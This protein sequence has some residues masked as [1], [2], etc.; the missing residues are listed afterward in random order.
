MLIHGIIV[1]MIFLLKSMIEIKRE[2]RKDCVYLKVDG[3]MLHIVRFIP[4]LKRKAILFL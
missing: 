2:L 3:N 4:Q 1:E